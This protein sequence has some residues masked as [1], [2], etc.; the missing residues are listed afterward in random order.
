[1]L[2]LDNHISTDPTFNLAL[3]EYAF[4][5]LPDGESLFML[6]QN[7]H[8]VIIG[9]HQNTIEEIDRSYVED[10]G[11]KVVRRL[12]GGGAVYHDLGN[13][14]FTFITGKDS[15][16]TFDFKTFTRPVIKALKKLGIDAEFNSRNDIAIDGKKISGNSQYAKRGRILH[17]GTLL[18]NAK[19][20]VVQ[21]ALKVKPE[22]IT[23]KGVK[24]VKSRV[25]NIIEY[26]EQPY[27]LE[28]F[29]K[30]L[31]EAMFETGTLT[32]WEPSEEEINAVKTL[33]KE[34]YE[35]WEWN[36]G[37]SP[38]Y[39]LRKDRK[40]PCGLVS[41]LMTIDQGIIRSIRF[42]GDF[43]GN[44]EISELE[45][46][47]KGICIEKASLLKALHSISPDDYISGMTD[48]EFLDLMLY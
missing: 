28:S 3:E 47:F 35:T 45:D 16:E 10:Q 42:Y 4:E 11:I 20:D 33:Q 38:A 17:H 12:T 48:E 39:D 31:T 40:Y 36:Y 9:K 29:R 7:D 19:L 24:S 23:S 5:H 2:F 1:M 6:W 30:A 18:F 21:K 22:K 44:R 37:E 25:T 41:V 32:A 15:K 27:T 46:H 14:N 26:L 13:L 43:F 8:A 34:K